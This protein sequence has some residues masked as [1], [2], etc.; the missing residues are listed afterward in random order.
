MK[1]RIWR[2]ERQKKCLVWQKKYLQAVL[3]NVEN[4]GNGIEQCRNNRLLE[5]IWLNLLSFKRS[6][7]IWFTFFSSLG[8]LESRL[9]ITYKHV[10]K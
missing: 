3:Q 5:T 10:M 2:L 9:S 8:T 1:L 7:F 6:L 4:E